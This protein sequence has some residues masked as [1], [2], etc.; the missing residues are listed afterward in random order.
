M[1]YFLSIFVACVVVFFASGQT[2]PSSDSSFNELVFF[3]NSNNK[4]YQD[5]EGSRYLDDQFVPVKIDSISG[6]R[7]V[8]FNV[9]E[10]AIE[11]KTDGKIG[12]LSLNESYV[13]RLQDGSNRIFSTQT[14]TDDEVETGVSFFE[15]VHNEKLFSIYLKEKIKYV[16]A[17]PEKSSYEPAKPANF[18]RGFEAFYL[19][20]SEPTDMPLQ[21]IPRRKKQFYKLF[22]AKSKLVEKFVKK[23]KLTIS[24]A[25]DLVKIFSYYSNQE[26]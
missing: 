3:V 9:V 21:E 11:I 10:N 7:F 25:N 20:K 13:L 12:R 19:K 24:T 23:E 15:N 14:Y 6:T 26:L 17:V 2:T 1:K 8:R 16:A 18:L 22:G 4:L 5:V